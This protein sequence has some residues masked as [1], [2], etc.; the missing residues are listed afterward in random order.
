[1]WHVTVETD[2]T[3]KTR[4]FDTEDQAYTFLRRRAEDEVSSRSTTFSWFVYRTS[5]HDE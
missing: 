3:Y 4:D 1:M 2:T 5:D